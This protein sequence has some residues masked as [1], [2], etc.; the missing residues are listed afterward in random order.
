MTTY[1]NLKG[2]DEV[3]ASLRGYPEKFRMRVVRTALSAGSRIIRDAGR[4]EAPVKSGQL[5]NTIRST[6]RSRSRTGK[7]TASV[8]VGKKNKGVFYGHMVIGGTQPHNILPKKGK[9][10]KFGTTFR[11]S[12]I[13][14]G[15]KANPF[16]DRAAAQ[17]PRALDAIVDRVKDLT[18]K[19]NEEVGGK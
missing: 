11:R 3:V 7:V 8:R 13:H 12:V 15:A 4:A 9:G 2:A 14:P 5:R 6:S 1:R 10:L 19:L 17:I 18:D 16:M